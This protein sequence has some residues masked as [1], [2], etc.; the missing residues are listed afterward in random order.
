[1]GYA[2]LGFVIES[3]TNKTYEDWLKETVLTP[4]NLTRTSIATP[5]DENVVKSTWFGSDLGIENP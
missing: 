1:M 4:L 2:I 3:V 5:T